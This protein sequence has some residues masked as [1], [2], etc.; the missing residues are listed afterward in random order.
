M[1]YAEG[2]EPPIKPACRAGA[3]ATRRGV[4]KLYHR[5]ELRCIIGTMSRTPTNLFYTMPETMLRKLVSQSRSISHVFDQL[6]LRKS[7]ASF[8]TF[9]AAVE[10][11]KIDVSHFITHGDLAAHQQ[12]SIRPLG[13]ILLPD[14]TV[15]N[16]TLR[17]KVLKHKLLP[18]RCQKCGNIGEWMGQ[19]IVL[20]IDHINGN[21]RDNRIE[22]LRFLCPNCH[23]QT[24]TF[25]G[26]KV[27]TV[28]HCVDC[29]RP[30]SG[31]GKRCRRCCLRLIKPICKIAW[32]S[33]DELTKMVWQKS[34]CLLAKDIDCSDVGLKKHCKTRSIPCP[35]I[36]YW[37]RREIGMSHEDALSPK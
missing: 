6:Q 31:N 25:C 11:R 20:P 5:H 23:S 24:E 36:G 26:R 14:V 34:I 22:N 28:H 1:V 21:R 12:A 17:N 8:K 7:G 2:L 35:P 37:R 30:V 9:R 29:S 33:D 32:P 16:T 10:A 13:E 3:M 18:Y 4:Q 27:K 15:S 19:S